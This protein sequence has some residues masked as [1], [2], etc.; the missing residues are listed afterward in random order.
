MNANLENA[1]RIILDFV[2]RRNKQD[3]EKEV[4]EAVE[5]VETYLNSFN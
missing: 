2:E 1:L 5:I 4:S 3:A